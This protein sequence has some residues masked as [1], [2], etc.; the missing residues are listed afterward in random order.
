MSKYTM[1][2]STGQLWHDVDDSNFSDF[3]STYPDAVVVE[4]IDEETGNGLEVSTIDMPIPED[5]VVEEVV[6]IN[7]DDKYRNKL[8]KDLSGYDPV[9]EILI[10][11]YEDLPTESRMKLTDKDAKIASSGNLQN[12]SDQGKK[13]ILTNYT[14]PIG[15]AGDKDFNGFIEVNKQAKE[16]MGLDESSE[17]D[18]KL[19]KYNED[20]KNA[21]SSVKQGQIPTSVLDGDLGAKIVGHEEEQ[22]YNTL[23]NLYSDYGFKFEETGLGDNVKV[24]APNGQATEISLD[25]WTNT[26]DKEQATKLKSFLDLNKGDYNPS[27]I[28]KIAAI[29]SGDLDIA[30]MEKI[31]KDERGEVDFDWVTNVFKGE[32][33]S[34]E[35]IKNFDAVYDADVVKEETQKLNN[36][37]IDVNQQYSKNK[38]AFNTYKL[39]LQN[40]QNE[41][42]QGNLSDEEIAEKKSLLA[43]TEQDILATD[44]RL[45]NLFS[46]KIQ[47]LQAQLQI[48]NAKKY[49]VEAEKGNIAGITA[50]TIL[51]VGDKITSYFN[52]GMLALKEDDIEKYWSENPEEGKKALAR[53]AE[54]AISKITE[55]YGADVSNEYEQEFNSTVA[56]GVYTSMIEMGGM[57]LTAALTGTGAVGYGALMGLSIAGGEM[58]EMMGEDF[59]GLSMKERFGLATTIG[60]V[61]GVIEGF[62]GYFGG[63][64]GGTAA[65]GVSSVVRKG[66]VGKVMNKLVGKQ[67]SKAAIKKTTNEIIEEGIKTGVYAL[68]KAGLKAGSAEA[69][70]EVAQEIATR[71][72]KQGVNSWKEKEIFDKMATE[73][74]M[75]NLTRAG[76]MGFLAGGPIGVIS[77]GYRASK[78]NAMDKISDRQYRMAKAFTL[79]KSFQQGYSQN[80][81]LQVMDPNNPMTQEQADTKLRDIKQQGGMMRELDGM[82]LTIEGEK[83]AYNLLRRK[84]ALQKQIDKATDK[85]IV[86]K[87]RED[88][89]QIN[90]QLEAISLQYNFESA[91][92]AGLEQAKGT[93]EASGKSFQEFENSQEFETKM[94]ELGAQDDNGFRTTSGYIDGKGN[95]YINKEGAKTLRDI[96]VG[97][98]EL[99]HGVMS[100]QLG[101]VG[102][103]TVQQFKNS[104][105]K[106]E[107]DILQPRIDSSYGGD[108][109]TEEYFNTFVD[110]VVKGDIKFNENIF[111]KIGDFITKNLLKPMGFSN[112]QLGFKDGRQVYNFVKDYAKQSRRIAQGQQ[113]GF[114]GEVGDIVAEGTA[115]RTTGAKSAQKISD[116]YKKINDFSKNPDFDI[117]SEFDTKRLLKEAGG[118][119]ESTTS[120]L[121][122]GTA[123]M[124][125]EGVSRESFKRDLE[126]LFAE[127]YKGYDEDMDVN[128]QGA[129]KQT[130]NLFNL[131]ANKLATDTFK[132]TSNEVR[133]DQSTLQIAA[134]NTPTKDNRTS[135]EIRQSERKG[136]KAR[137]KV[138]GIYKVDAIVESIR[139]KAK[140]KSFKGKNIK[141]LKG[142]ALKEVVDMISRNNKELSDSMFIKLEKNSDLNKAEMLSIQKFINSNI[143]LAKGSLLEGYT[144]KFKAS[145]VVNKLL[146]KFYNKRSVRAKTGAGLEIQIKKPNISD[147]E[148]KEAFGITGKDQANWNQKVVA[149]KGGVSDILK[150][151]VR[152]FDQVISSQ[153]IRE[154]KIIDGD[155]ESASEL[156]SAIPQGF[157]SKNSNAN[158]GKSFDE[159]LNDIY[160]IEG[161]AN[162]D[163]AQILGDALR[164][165]LFENPEETIGDIITAVSN[166]LEIKEGFAYEQVLYDVIN[167][168]AAQYNIPGLQLSSGPTEVGGAADIVLTYYGQEIGI[169]AKK[170]N[171][172]FGSVTAKYDEDGNL[173]IKKDYTFN[174]LLNKM[175]KDA[176]PEID[177]YVKEANVIGKRLFGEKYVSIKYITDA[178]PQEVYNELQIKGFQK[179]ITQNAKVNTD[180]VSELYWAKQNGTSYI[181]IQG[182]GTYYLTDPSNTNLE[183]PLNLDVPPFSADLILSFA[184]GS[185]T[186]NNPAA[187]NNNDLEVKTKNAKGNPLKRA[188]PGSTG[189]RR[190]SLRFQPSK[191]TGLEKSSL[192]LDQPASV[193]K[194]FN[195]A[196]IN[197]KITK[198]QEGAFEDNQQEGFFSKVIDPNN[199]NNSNIINEFGKI[200]KALELANSLDQPIKKIRVFD[201]DDTLATSSNLVFA[202][203][204]GETITLNAEEFAKKGDKLLNEGYEF[205]FTDFNTVRDGKQGPLFDIAKR[206]K[207]ARGNED[208]FVLTARNPKAQPAIYEFLKSKGLE[209]PLENIVGLGN[210]TGEAKAQWLVGKAADGYND[211]YFADD[212][213]QNVTAVKKAMSVLDVKSKVQQARPKF[214]KNLSEDFNRIIEETEG[215]G[216]EKTFSEARAKQIGSQRGKRKFWIPFSAEDMLGLIYPI[217]GK[218]KTGDAQMKFFKD[219]LFNPFSKAMESLAASRVQLMADFK[220]LKKNMDVPKDLQKE[221]FDGFTNEQALRMYIWDLQGVE[222]PGASKRD[223][224]DA[225]K[226]IEGNEKLKTFAEELIKINKEDGYPNPSQ[227]WL[228]GTITT[229]L[230]EGLNDVKR[231]RYLQQWQQNVD[232]IFSKDNLNKLE[233]IH[234]SN[235]REAL[236]NMLTRMKTGKNRI[237]GS[238]RMSDKVLDWIN[239]SVGAI[240]FFN[241][242]SAVLQLISSINF[243]NLSDNNLYSA[244]KAF[245]NQP[246]YWSDFKMLMNSDFLVDRRNGL[247]INVSESEIADA[248]KT[249]K[250]KARAVLNY[251]LKK[252]FLP[253]Q[254]ADSFAIASGGA[255]F[256]RN[257]V[258]TYLSEGMNKSEAEAKAFTDFREISEES[259]QSSRPDKVSQ[260][261]AS[262]LGRVL[263]AFANTPMQ[264]GRLTKRAYQDLINGRGDRKSN[265]SKI[266]Y[267][268]AV[269]NMIFNVLQQ[270]VTMLGFGDDEKDDEEKQEKYIDV[271]NGM[272][273][274]I[275][276]GLGI[277]GGA[278]SVAKNFLLDLYER[279][280]RTRPEYVDSVYKLLQF[281]PPISSKV[282]KIRQAAWMFDSKKRRKEIFDKGFALDNPAYEAAGKVIS[283]TTNLPVDRVYNKINNIDAAL[284][285]DTETWESIAMLLGWPEWQIKSKPK[286]KSKKG[287][288]KPDFKRRKNKRNKTVFR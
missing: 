141:Q 52:G 26:G 96:S 121:Y 94:K 117:D 115:G 240:M 164:I 119:I 147:V 183:N 241:T 178:M 257:R 95:I 109:T 243:V 91:F 10:D 286:Y 262:S 79:N 88:I 285:E 37:L 44:K 76:A 227:S 72:I 128:M 71:K 35:I 282:S 163:R 269:Q 122:D 217:L 3:M 250:N 7:P 15:W 252:G 258:N 107:L 99:L 100:K 19:N 138:V 150:G 270:A 266:I 126:A 245:A 74:T 110:A 172:R 190:I 195:Q 75:S 205:D 235:Y 169:E 186:A 131:R 61:N 199:T 229:D 149:K 180:F 124:N 236:E 38:A 60:A 39:D 51:G 20:L 156:A 264:Y 136:V 116:S 103:E 12:M 5:P 104:L 274:S 194:A 197:N 244:G 287:G 140:G 17:Y 4:E 210:S 204:D 225:K 82:S 55:K 148:F 170:G 134:D 152:N 256:Y 142:F 275:L 153:E 120:R 28:K 161:I 145:G 133:S 85:A 14:F 181:Q 21:L 66:I 83:K 212:A 159:I 239:G 173:I 123:Q 8:Q 281:S 129:G 78:A 90:E 273:D 80:L 165:K 30:A 221:A 201:F 234:G 177:A 166:G 255:T 29:A 276:R 42:R 215:I 175:L 268:T 56:G 198:E 168:A 203:K 158:E 57:M 226:I 228:A 132:Q 179:R 25:N 32:K 101:N 206:I 185:N 214:S 36:Q 279:S 182:L 167:D 209:I 220:A 267:Y 189:F 92:E 127:I 6:E 113:E 23:N 219:N 146:E 11:T 68:T 93:T 144:S 16:T 2:D 184:T 9:R 137:E 125:K 53:E 202:N 98:H 277:A 187:Y 157:F 108:P 192:Q 40:L 64:I 46:T 280:G 211:F 112:A 63:M 171:A 284:A 231:P 13:T 84:K 58:E 218:G 238:N 263:L 272:A 224:A 114:E 67:V 248:A 111:T 33:V 105:S 106:S 65:K 24:Y 48:V 50:N 151:F 208:L 259:Q 77:A 230:I 45:G 31:A 278:V 246:Q 143:D 34:D 188:L 27:N 97:Q 247:K 207:A 118:I 222:V 130:S 260:Q 283:A 213:M 216:R 73:I 249:S 62:G 81:Q 176:K 139:Q 1:R 102:G 253:T 223:V 200:D 174:K 87:Q 233:A 242:R 155:A 265:I 160:G 43:K 86:K 70:T 69:V 162:E 237:Q 22:V 89:T 288:Y 54:L 135:R 232:A 251:I 254:I 18:S 196:D 41:I 49:V 154:Q 271:A 191:I 261:Q 47:P 59:E 193:A